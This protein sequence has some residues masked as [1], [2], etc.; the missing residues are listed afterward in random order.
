MSDKT[1]LKIF[2]KSMYNKF[3][4]GVMARKPRSARAPDLDMF[5]VSLHTV[6]SN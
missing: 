6:I 5:T 4:I 2:I 3:P 1:K